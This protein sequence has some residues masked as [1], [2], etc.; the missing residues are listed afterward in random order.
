MR[1][2]SDHQRTARRRVAAAWLGAA[3][4]T[5]CAVRD[6]PV[7]SPDGPTFWPHAARG[8]AGSRPGGT[9]TEIAYVDGYETAARRARA[10]GRPLLLV[11]RASWC[12]WS[13]ALVRGPLADPRLVALTRRCVCTQVD[14]DRDAATCRAFAVTAF[15]TVVVVDAAGRECFRGTGAAA[16]LGLAAAIDP[17]PT[18]GAVEERVAAGERQAGASKDVTR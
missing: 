1:L 10:D 11:F 4:V 3:I 15:P 14:A 2:R 8:Q 17:V 6:E 9:E 16:T 13:G 7:K 5:G 18:S 12:R